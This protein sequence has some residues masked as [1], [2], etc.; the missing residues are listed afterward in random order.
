[1]FS[2]IAGDM[3]LAALLDAGAPLSELRAALSGLPVE[4]WA[5]E[6]EAVLRCGI[7]AQS[8]SVSCMGEPTKKSWLTPT[9]ITITGVRCA[10]SKN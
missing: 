8:V 3:T 4:G 1:L 10:K 5:I 9:I 6:S 2:G 7:H